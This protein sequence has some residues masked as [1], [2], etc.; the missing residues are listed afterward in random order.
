MQALLDELDSRGVAYDMAHF[1]DLM[2]ELT[3]INLPDSTDVEEGARQYLEALK[4]QS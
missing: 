3:H 4:R 1:H 2:E